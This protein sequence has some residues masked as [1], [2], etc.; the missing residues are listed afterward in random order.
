[1]PADAVIF[2]L[3]GTLVDSHTDIMTSV[4]VAL[5]EVGVT[6]PSLEDLDA[7]LGYPL[8][9]LYATLLPEGD[10]RGLQRF[11]HIYRAHYCDHCADRTRPYPGVV[12]ALD[13]LADL[14]LGVATAKPT[15]SAVQLLTRLGLAHRFAA[16]LGSERHPPKPHPG[17]L[18]TAARRLGVAPDRCSM[19]G[20]TGRDIQAAQ[21][22]GMRAVAVSW[23]GWPREKLQ[24][25]SP[26]ALLDTPGQ[27]PA[28]V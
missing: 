12:E 21:A 4:Q 9:E 24:T 28:A 10:A 22:A 27:I 18:L 26:D 6:G 1:M 11:V 16:I 13:A 8:T 23:G 5:A 7:Y 3:D 25:L 19:L 14:P 2:D 15:W 20:D 17:V